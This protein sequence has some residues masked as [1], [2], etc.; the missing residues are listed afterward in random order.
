MFSTYTDLYHELNPS[1]V[2]VLLRQK[3]QE[4]YVLN[5]IRKDDILVNE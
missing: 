2:T 3:L 1:T 5:P 4:W